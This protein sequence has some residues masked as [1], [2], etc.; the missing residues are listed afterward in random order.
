[1]HTWLWTT[2]SLLVFGNDLR[3]MADDRFAVR[4]Q[5]SRRADRFYPANYLMLARGTE[6]RDAEVRHRC[7]LALSERGRRVALDGLRLHLQAAK[8]VLGGGDWPLTEPQMEEIWAGGPEL[9]AAIVNVAVECKLAR[10]GEEPTGETSAD[11][12]T[13]YVNVVRRRQRGLMDKPEKKP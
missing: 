5:A 13:G 9:F 1:M 7:R 12:A 3:D 2:L 10:R 6:S 8:L 11:L 4:E